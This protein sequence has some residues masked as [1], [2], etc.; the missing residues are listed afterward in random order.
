MRR[1]SLSLLPHPDDFGF[2][3]HHRPD[4]SS[5]FSFNRFR[6]LPVAKLESPYHLVLKSL[7]M[8]TGLALATHFFFV[9]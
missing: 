3:A 2:A 6:A 9:L 4:T 5:L 1:A 8:G 7:M